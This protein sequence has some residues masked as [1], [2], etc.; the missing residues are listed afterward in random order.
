MQKKSFLS[1]LIVLDPNSISLRNMDL[2]YELMAKNVYTSSATD[3]K[4]TLF[5]LNVKMDAMMNLN[6]LM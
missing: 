2:Y 3:P 1:L 6:Q 5:F 4:L